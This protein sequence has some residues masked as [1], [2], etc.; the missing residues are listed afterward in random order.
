MMNQFLAVNFSWLEWWG[1]PEDIEEMQRSYFEQRKG[2]K[3][4]YSR[5]GDRWEERWEGTN[6]N[7]APFRHADDGCGC[8]KREKCQRMGKAVLGGWLQSLQD[9]TLVWFKVPNWS[10]SIGWRNYELKTI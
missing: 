9:Y 1:L 3:G 8:W 5:C 6:R 7:K 4:D 10:L 2:R